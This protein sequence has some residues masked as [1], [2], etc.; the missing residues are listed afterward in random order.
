[1]LKANQRE[2][3]LHEQHATRTPTS[4]RVTLLGLFVCFAAVA[5]ARPVMRIVT[6][7]DWGVVVLRSCSSVPAEEVKQ[8]CDMQLTPDVS[9]IASQQVELGK[10]ENWGKQCQCMQV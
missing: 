8:L 5:M 1:M 10:G 7:K 6:L 4:A 3:Q 9:L 2:R